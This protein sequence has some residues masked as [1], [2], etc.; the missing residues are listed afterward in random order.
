MSNKKLKILIFDNYLNVVK[1][2]PGTK[3]FQ[4]L[5]FEIG[6]KKVDITK[7][8]ELSCTYFMSSILMILHLLDIKKAPHAKVDGLIKNIKK[9]GWRKISVSNLNPGDII[10]WEKTKTR[11]KHSGFYIGS[12][13]AISN[14]TSKKH[15]IKHHYTYNGKR[16]IVS[17]WRWPEFDK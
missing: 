15:P 7:N 16:K 4:N 1:K 3:M 14:S 13:K 5:F 11:H 12:D 9:F 6:G 2:S 8:G 10:I 17:C